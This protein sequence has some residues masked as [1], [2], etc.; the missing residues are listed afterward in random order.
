MTHDEAYMD[1]ALRLATR[2]SE[3]GE[4]PVGALVVDAG[5]RV[6][7]RGSNSMER[8]RRVTR[9][10]E[11]VAMDAASRRLRNWRLTGCTI[12]VTLEPCPMCASALSLSRAARIVYGADDPLAGA[13]GSVYNIP[14]DGRLKAKPS[15]TGGVRAGECAALLRSFFSGR[16]RSYR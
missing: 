12:Y 16:R 3:R 14:A 5:G 10:A 4:V 11:L 2:A 6:I 13:C 15:V 7:G 1:R 9:H 8:S